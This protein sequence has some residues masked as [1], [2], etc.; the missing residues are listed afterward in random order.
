MTATLSTS[1]GRTHNLSEL[2]EVIGNYY[3]ADG[4]AARGAFGAKA[5]TSCGRTYEGLAFPDGSGVAVTCTKCED[6]A[7]APAATPARYFATRSAGRYRVFDRTSESCTA[8]AVCASRAKAEEKAAKLNAEATAEEVPVTGDAVRTSPVFAPLSEA[9]RETIA[10]NA[11][12]AQAPAAKPEADTKA[13]RIGK[14]LREWVTEDTSRISSA[15]GAHIASR[16]VCY[17]GTATLRLT[18]V[19]AEELSAAATELENAALSG[20][21]QTKAPAVMAARAARKGLAKLF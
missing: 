2:R 13:Y 9:A 3:V 4:D 20:E 11:D 15:L 21:F 14:I 7:E 12:A 10:R 1:T 18:A 19:W 16:N 17:D 5:R 8:I 6:A